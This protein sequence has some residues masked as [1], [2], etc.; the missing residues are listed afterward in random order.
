MPVAGPVPT[1]D[2]ISTRL[3]TVDY[4]VIY[5]PLALLSLGD[6][7]AVYRIYNEA[8]V[9]IH[10]I[11]S[12]VGTGV[13][14]AAGVPGARADIAGYFSFE[15]F[16]ATHVLSPPWAP[17]GLPH[18]FTADSIGYKISHVSV[19]HNLKESVSA[20]TRDHPK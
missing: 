2:D 10:F 15:G 14:R 7:P 3:R 1:Q 16:F 18:A 13:S 12:A 9:N 11:P 19:I 6:S 5:Y 20:A 4:T 8:F 17:S